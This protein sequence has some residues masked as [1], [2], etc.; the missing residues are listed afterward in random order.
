M[1]GGFREKL[2]EA[3][4]EARAKMQNAPVCPSCGKPMTKRKATTGINAGKDF[5]GCTGYPEC[6]GVRQ[7]QECNP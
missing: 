3:R 1:K 4:I 7:I 6:K 5:W 2:T